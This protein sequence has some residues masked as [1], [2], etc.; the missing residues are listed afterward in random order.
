MRPGHNDARMTAMSLEIGLLTAGV[1]TPGN[2]LLCSAGSTK[3]YVIA[4]W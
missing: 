3:A 4:S 1:T 2:S